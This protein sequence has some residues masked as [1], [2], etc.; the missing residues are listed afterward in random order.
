MIH[1]SKIIFYVKELV[2][3]NKKIYF[4]LTLFSYLILII[5]N[6]NLK[7]G[8]NQLID[9][10]K[11]LDKISEISEKVFD[12]SK[13]KGLFT[14]DKKKS[15]LEKK[16]SDDLVIY[17]TSPRSIQSTEGSFEIHVSSFNPILSVRI[18]DTSLS[19]DNESFEFSYSY[20]NNILNP[21]ENILLIEVITINGSTDK[22]FKIFLEDSFYKFAEMRKSSFTLVN[23]LGF[24][25]D[26]NVNSAPSDKEEAMKGS[27]TIVAVGQIVTGYSSAFVITSIL[28]FDDQFN[29][30]YDSKQII[31]RQIGIDWNDQKTDFGD[32]TIGSGTSMVGLWDKE[33][34]SQIRDPFYDKYKKISQE[35]FFQFKLKVDF[36]EL[37]KWETSLKYS[38]KDDYSMVTSTQQKAPKIY[39]NKIG[40]G[41]ETKWFDMTWLMSLDYSQT[42]AASDT[43]D[44]VDSGI[45]FKVTWPMKT[46][47]MNF[48]Y[49]L[50]DQQYKTAEPATGVRT[51]NNSSYAVFG[52][53]YQVYAWLSLAY[54]HRYEVNE[55]NIINSDYSKNTDSLNFTI[56]F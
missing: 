39:V 38:I 12:F 21:G 37:L 31:F 30:K 43:K 8:E 4:F 16:E 54:S 2:K 24:N 55:S 42:D 23:V 9:L 26:N 17:I 5:G 51:H 46:I 44:F 34:Q 27:L 45:S 1:Y 49:G 11:R 52:A 50:T 22:E 40:Q 33:R 6:T 35:N 10:D 29:S 19:V 25:R 32:F 13:S 28:N 53:N 41:F 3:N 47:P 7:A 18:N 15:S 56:I 48:Q 20:A 14:I 36:Q